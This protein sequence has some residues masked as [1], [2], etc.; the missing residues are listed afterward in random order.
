MEQTSWFI[1]R[2]RRMFVDFDSCTTKTNLSGWCGLRVRFVGRLLIIEVNDTSSCNG[3]S[4]I[5]L[6]GGLVEVRDRI[7]S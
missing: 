6:D 4:I 2:I 3:E 5:L 1:D 7:T